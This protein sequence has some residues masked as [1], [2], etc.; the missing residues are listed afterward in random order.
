MVSIELP[1]VEERE[2]VLEPRLRR[3]RGSG[4]DD[5]EA[6]RALGGR[7]AVGGPR[8]LRLTSET[9]NEGQ[10][11]PMARRFLEQEAADF[12]F[13]LVHMTCTFRPVHDELFRKAVLD[14]ELRGPATAEVESIAWSMQPERLT[15]PR[16]LTSVVKL[17][18]SMKILGMG[19]EWEVSRSEERQI[20]DVFLQA[21]YE[22]LP[23][24]RWELSSTPA[25]AIAGQH[26]FELVV[27]AP[28]G[29]RTDARATVGATVRRR[30]LGLIPYQAA[31]AGGSTRL[32]FA[33]P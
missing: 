11:E 9:L 27:R 8:T 10:L 4:V 21:F 7:L 30:R 33:L 6:H 16:T 32:D 13:Y 23:T 14:I 25:V 22:G 18:P 1:K 20:E 24:P 3:L 19:L 26:R 28:K 5:P 17:T 15:R 31:V 12:D 2:V 29:I